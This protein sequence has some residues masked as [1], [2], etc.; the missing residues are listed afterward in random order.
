MRRTDS[1]VGPE[2]CQFA[3]RAFRLDNR[4]HQSSQAPTTKNPSS[5]IANKLISFM[6]FFIN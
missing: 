2:A 1:T 4:H 5:K 6:A 3:D